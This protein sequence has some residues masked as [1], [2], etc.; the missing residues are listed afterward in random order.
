MWY[1]IKPRVAPLAVECP[2][3]TLIPLPLSP[4]A[5]LGTSANPGAG[6][7]S[8]SLLEE[9]SPDHLLTSQRKG[10]PMIPRRLF[11]PHSTSC[12]SPNCIRLCKT[13]LFVGAVPFA[14]L[15][16]HIHTRLMPLF[17]KAYPK[18]LSQGINP[19]LPY[20]R[21]LKPPVACSSILQQPPLSAGEGRGPM[22]STE[23]QHLHATRLHSPVGP[24][25]RLLLQ[26]QPTPTHALGSLWFF[27]HWT[28]VHDPPSPPGL[29]ST[30]DLS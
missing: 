20:S 30:S 3:S 29:A 28:F 23:A 26:R 13:S 1:A 12:P 21:F 9:S 18:H 5:S 16:H 11:C 7:A 6:G 14:Y 22:P 25:Q 4:Q 8:M 2:Q 19:S 15:H 27:C 24:G 17:L 10:L